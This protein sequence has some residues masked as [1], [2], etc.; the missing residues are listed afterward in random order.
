M[1]LAN[2][3]CPIEFRIQLFAPSAVC[4]PSF[5]VCESGNR[6][7][8]DICVNSVYLSLTDSGRLRLR[9]IPLRSQLPSSC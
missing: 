9:L 7:R 6:T 3:L 8:N 5:N 2:M 4:T 1:K